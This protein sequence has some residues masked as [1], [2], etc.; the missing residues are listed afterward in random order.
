MSEPNEPSL[1]ETETTAPLRAILIPD[2]APQTETSEQ[3]AEE[4]LGVDES[5][6]ADSRS[7]IERRRCRRS[8]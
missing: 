3:S 6:A 4:S 5:S 8:R 1:N 7:L 2:H